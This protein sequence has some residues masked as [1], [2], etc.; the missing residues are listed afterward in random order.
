M[1]FTL[2]RLAWGSWALMQNKRCDERTPALSVGLKR[3]KTASPH[4]DSKN[5]A[6]D[7]AADEPA[8]GVGQAIGPKTSA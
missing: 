3:W 8:L 2:T 4:L 6:A 5:F 1:L 7:A